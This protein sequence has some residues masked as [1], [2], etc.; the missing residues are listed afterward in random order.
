MCA[1]CGC[2]HPDI[3]H[4]HA[5]AHTHEV[6]HDHGRNHDDG[7]SHDHGHDH[8]HDMIRIERDVLAKN[9]ALAAGNRAWFAERQIL[10]V[11]LMGAPGAGKTTVLEKTIAVLAPTRSI[12]VI[13]G[14]QATERDAERIRQAGARAVQINTGTGCHLDAPMVTRAAVELDPQPHSIVM[15]E[16]VGNLVCPALFFLGE[17]V[18]VVIVSVTEGD[19]KPIKYPHMV[20][21]AT[22]ML[23][24]KIDLLAHVDFSLA[25]CIDGARR[26]NPQLEVIEVSAVTG[27]GIQRWC[28][29]LNR[30]YARAQSPSPSPSP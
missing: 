1:T 14:D 3:D 9:N 25:R 21:S 4:D 24:N 26:V 20:R 11:N 22:L 18:R 30:H 23:V 10:A 2:G 5:H 27:A 13:E 8:G 17:A 12:H 16:N 7:H 15:I 19:D 28:E 6:G 29:W